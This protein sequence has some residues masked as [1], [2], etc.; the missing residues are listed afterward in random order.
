MP[1]PFHMK[2][3]SILFLFGEFVDSE[4]NAT[5]KRIQLD[6]YLHIYLLYLFTVKL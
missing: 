6:R 4:N 3:C 5:M 2:T 1:N